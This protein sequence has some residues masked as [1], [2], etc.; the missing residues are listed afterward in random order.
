[1]AVASRKPTVPPAAAERGGGLV[2]DL[3]AGPGRTLAE[4]FANLERSPNVQNLTRHPRR[5][6]LGARVALTPEEGEGFWDFTQIG[7]HVYVIAGDC[8]YINPRVELVPGDGLIQFY[9]NLAGDLTLEV[10]RT[11]PLRFNRPSLLVYHQPGGVDMK[12]WVSP[13]A[14]ER[15][16]AITMRAE[17]LLDEFLIDPAD[18]PQQLRALVSGAPGKLQY[19]QLPLSSQMFDLANRLVDKPHRG[20]LGLLYTEALTQELLCLAVA[21]FDMLAQAP[22]EEYSERDLR[23]LHTARAILMK[24]LASPPSIRELARAAGMNETSLKRGF[25]AVF[26]ETMFDFSV[27]CRMQHALVLLRDKKMPVAR[28]SEAVGYSHQTTFATAFKRHF[29]L[30]P[31][32]VRPIRSA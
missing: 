11:E 19:C 29:G 13:N 20:T 1:M 9:F 17:Y 12:E 21:S 15:L 3:L 32:D 7:D 23:C 6:L 30:S 22:R 14:R 18:A 31:K 2:R 28:V 27:R 25:K 4:A 26:G 24:Q 5:R 8:T 16:V 10:S